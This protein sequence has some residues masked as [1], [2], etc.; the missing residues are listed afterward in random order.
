MVAAFVGVATVIAALLLTGPN[1]G[2]VYDGIVNQALRIRDAL[3]TPMQFP[4]AGLDWGFAAVAGAALVAVLPRGPGTPR[5][6]P[7]L[8]RVLAG[9]AIWMAIAQVPPLNVN[10]TLIREALPL[11]LAWIA[12]IPPV[13][14]EEPPFKRFVRVLL[15]ALAVAEALQIYPVAGS[16]VG[17]AAATFVPVGALCIAD[18]LAS[19]RRW[20]AASGPETALRLGVVVTVVLLAALGKFGYESIVRPGLTSLKTYRDLPAAS[21]PGAGLLHIPPPQAEEYEA[22]VELLHSQN[23]TTLVGQPSINSLYLWSG[24]EAPKPQVPGPWVRLLDNATQQRIVDQLKAS[25][26]PCAV[27]NEAETNAWLNGQPLPSSPWSSTCAKTSNRSARSGTRNSSSPRAA[28]ELQSSPVT[29][30]SRTA[31]ITSSTWAAERSGQRGSRTSRALRS[32]VTSSS[33]LVR[34]KRRP[35]GELCRGT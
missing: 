17:I 19:L 16:Q 20:A 11:T 30:K 2:D 15:P 6:W 12:A 1:L 34:P 21:L 24:L 35:A 10:S 7:G 9:A 3:V 29:R 4:S 13:D 23:C 27:R 22:L 8:L 33:P 32:S 25:P 28:A 26:R 5:I 14:V 18:G 31:A